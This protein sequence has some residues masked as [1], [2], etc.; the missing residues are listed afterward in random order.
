MGLENTQSNY[1]TQPTFPGG[2][3]TQQA[4]QSPMDFMGLLGLLMGAQTE[5]LGMKLDA[6]TTP[7]SKIVRKDI[8]GNVIGNQPRGLDAWYAMNPGFARGLTYEQGL[9]NTKAM[10]QANM[11]ETM[12]GL[13]SLFNTNLE[14]RN[15]FLDNG[16]NTKK[17]PT[18]PFRM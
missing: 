12:N 7:Q 16:G 5:Q 18:N 4:Q 1:T 14:Q 11:M 8:S 13:A 2:V 3:P 10:G 6:L 17:L 15:K 9:A